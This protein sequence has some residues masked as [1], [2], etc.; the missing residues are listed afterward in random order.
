VA[1]C[2]DVDKNPPGTPYKQTP[3]A[4]KQRNMAKAKTAK[5]RPAGAPVIPSLAS[6][7]VPR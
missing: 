6:L 4:P 3:V 5:A 1:M 7:T 2:L